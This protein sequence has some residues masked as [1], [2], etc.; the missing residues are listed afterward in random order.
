MDV[1]FSTYANR[2]DPERLKREYKKWHKNTKFEKEDSDKL[3]ADL[4]N[5]LKFLSGMDAKEYLLYRKWLEIKEWAKENDFSPKKSNLDLWFDIDEDDPILWPIVSKL[6]YFKAEKIW[7]PESPEDY[8]K[9]KPILVSPVPSLIKYLKKSLSDPNSKPAI[10]TE[11]QPELSDYNYLNTFTSKG[12]NNQNVGRNLKFIV[13]DELTGKILGYIC[14]SSDFLDLT[15]RDDYIGWSRKVRTKQKMINHTAIG[16]GIVPTQPLGFNYMGGKLLALLTISNITEE[17]WSAKYG[18]RLV[19]YTTTS[20]YGSFSQY[21]SLK[22][23]KKLGRTTGTI[24]FEPSKEI[25]YR[26]RKWLMYN[27]PVKYWEWFEA[28]NDKGL[29]FKRDHKQRFLNFVYNKFGIKKNLIETNHERGVYFCELYENTRPFLR[30]EIDERQ[31]GKKLFDNSVEA[32]T[33]LWKKKY[34]KK[35]IEE[36][37]K[38]NRYSTKTLVYDDLLF[39]QSWEEVKQKYASAAH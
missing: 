14:V 23:W 30:K 7:I 24:K 21:N 10:D 20:L 26:M 3:K 2:T 32:L 37:L 1:D 4:M 9:L 33:A 34:A 25:V 12:L 19:G 16:S 18:D 6:E 22:Y 8:L 38:N 29:P 17:K 5:E 39:M 28:K 15:P 36:L 13:L 27:H 31:L 35:R 11:N